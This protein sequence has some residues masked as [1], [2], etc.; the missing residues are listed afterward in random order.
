M[1]EVDDLASGDELDNKTVELESTS[2]DDQFEA[3]LEA[4]V[5][6]SLCFIDATR[7]FCFQGLC[8]HKA[9]EDCKR[10]S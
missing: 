3:L 7:T 2:R 1:A 10:R 5:P 4:E 8:S 9:I 6:L